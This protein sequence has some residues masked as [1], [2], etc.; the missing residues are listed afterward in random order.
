MPDA[1]ATEVPAE[2]LDAGFTNAVFFYTS[3]DGAMTFWTPVTGGTSSEGVYPR[4]ELRELLD[5]D[6]ENQ[7]WSGYGTNVL[8]AQC[9]VTRIPSSKMV[10]IG[11]IHTFTGNA[12][13]LVKLQFNTEWVEA[14]VKNRPNAPAETAYLFGNIGPS[15][16]ISNQIR[17]E[18]GL[19]SINVNGSNRTVN[20]FQADPAWANQAFFFKAGCYCQDNSG[21]SAEGARVAFYQL[22]VEH[23]GRFVPDPVVVLTNLTST[24]GGQVRFTVL[25]EGPGNYF[26]QSSTNLREWRYFLVTNSLEGQFTVVDP[27][28]PGQRFYRGGRLGET[29]LWDESTDGSGN[30]GFTLFGPGPG[31]YFIQSSTDLVQWTHRLFTNSST[32]FFEFKETMS[33]D[34]AK[35]YR[36]GSF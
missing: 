21:P 22:S 8:T 1:N 34:G 5:P 27:V 15:N 23:V 24:I 18:D 17:L 3:S 35:F 14:L 10:I 29:I 28:G 11:Q 16:L 32:G 13:P 30:F 33:A 19:L 4:S 6:N 2:E 12:L 26:V 9:R 20:V 25:G 31:N 7:N 36:G